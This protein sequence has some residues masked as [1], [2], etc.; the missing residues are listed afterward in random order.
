MTEDPAKPALSEDAVQALAEL[1]RNIMYPA[2]R[3]HVGSQFTDRR[4][5]KYIVGP[6]GNHIAVKGD[7]E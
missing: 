5:Q 1:L 4:G 2:G 6:R 7:K 3:Q